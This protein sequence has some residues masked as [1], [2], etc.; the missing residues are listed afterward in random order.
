MT[1]C[2]KTLCLLLVAVFGLWGCARN[3]SSQSGSDNDKLKAL[4]AKTAKLEEDLKSAI[5]SKEQLRKKL[6][7]CQDVQAQLQQEVE[8]L[9]IVVKER[10]ELKTTL[11]TRTAERDLTQSKYE[12]FLKEL[13]D[14]TGRA[15]AALHGPRSAPNGG[16]GDYC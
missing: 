11:K 13:D 14:L 7:E 6:A 12:G 3:P 5:A 4:E 9:Q 10:D 2:N 1:P 16:G 8:R 15:K